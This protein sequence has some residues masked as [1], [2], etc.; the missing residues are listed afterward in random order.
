MLNQ[1]TITRIAREVAA[2]NLSSAVVRDVITE[3]MV[4]SCG[5]EALRVMIVI[6][7]G[8][9]ERLP[10]DALLETLYQ[11]S[12]RLQTAGEERFPFVE[13]ATTE[14]LESLADTES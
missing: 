1:E 11:M 6:A 13:Y 12:K 3:P 4:D 8:T 5:D 14:E 2:A 9:E 10:G 7:P